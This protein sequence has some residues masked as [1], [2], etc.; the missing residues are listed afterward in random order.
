MEVVNLTLG[1]GAKAVLE[2]VSLK[3]RI[4]D[5]DDLRPSPVARCMS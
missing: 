5:E 3:F 1:F 2:R 4:F